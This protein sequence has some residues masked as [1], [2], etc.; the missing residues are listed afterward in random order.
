MFCKY[1]TRISQSQLKIL[2][3]SH[4]VWSS[5]IPIPNPFVDYTELLLGTN[6]WWN[7]SR[8]V[9]MSDYPINKWWRTSSVKT[10]VKQNHTEW[11]VASANSPRVK[12]PEREA[13]YIHLVLR[14][15]MC[16][17][18]FHSTLFGAWWLNTEA[19]ILSQAMCKWKCSNKLDFLCVL[20][21]GQTKKT[22]K[23]VPVR[24]LFYFRT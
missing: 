17:A 6:K 12:R 5:K 3:F 9:Q 2:T 13:K 21:I 24:N 18:Y 20:C 23:Q 11:T 8:S 22:H 10:S 7:E 16:V 4:T 1:R 15:K 19:D 14:W